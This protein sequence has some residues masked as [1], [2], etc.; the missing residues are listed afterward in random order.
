[1]T[2]SWPLHPLKNIDE[3]MLLPIGKSLKAQAYQIWI[4][5]KN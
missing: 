2:L 3:D 5:K 4:D 1:M